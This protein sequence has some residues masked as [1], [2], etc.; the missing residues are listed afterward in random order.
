MGGIERGGRTA[1]S[2]AMEDTV[3]QSRRDALLGQSGWQKPKL[4]SNDKR[5]VLDLS[6]V[7]TVRCRPEPQ[8]LP[9]ASP[10]HAPFH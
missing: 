5:I 4:G 7:M 8:P 1:S 2:T 9:T 10:T 6:P 3:G